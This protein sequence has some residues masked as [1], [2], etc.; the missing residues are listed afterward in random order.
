MSAD[1]EFL[2]KDAV[3]VEEAEVE[4]P[5]GGGRGAASRHRKPKDD[6]CP[7]P[8]CAELKRKGARFCPRHDK[9]YCNMCYQAEVKSVEQLEEFNKKM[10]PIE[11]AATEVE[12]FATENAGVA[13][14]KHKSLIEWG[15]FNKR[16]GIILRNSEHTQNAP[17]EKMQW[18]IRQKNKFGREETVATAAWENFCLQAGRG[19]RSDNL[20][21]GG[22]LRL[23]LP[24]GEFEDNSREKF[25]EG[26]LNTGSARKKNPNQDW[27]NAMKMMPHDMFKSNVGVGFQ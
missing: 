6:T 19:I 15:E 14:G 5:R 11:V 7:I 13:E 25:I 8:V 24:K 20:G 16:H 23:W 17:F 27:S 18:I 21:F 22:Q 1:D 4:Q 9:L 12:K 26:A 3:G 10:K 2:C